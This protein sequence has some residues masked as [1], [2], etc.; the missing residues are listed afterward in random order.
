MIG[1]RL[2]H[3]STLW[4][5]SIREATPAWPVPFERRCIAST[6]HARA[7]ERTQPRSTRT[8]RDR[9]TAL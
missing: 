6:S 3:S 8:G 7:G 9:H 5:R 2:I 4:M 1:C